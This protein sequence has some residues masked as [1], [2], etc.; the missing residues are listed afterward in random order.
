MAPISTP[1]INYLLVNSQVH[2]PH[3]L[4][5]STLL[6]LNIELGNGRLR[7]GQQSHCAGAE[8]G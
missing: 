3:H 7:D 2:H 8:A 4:Y 1:M 6:T 5:L